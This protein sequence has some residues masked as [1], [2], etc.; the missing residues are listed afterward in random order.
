MFRFVAL[1]AIFVVAIGTSVDWDQ[2][3]ASLQ[4]T[5]NNLQDFQRSLEKR[6]QMLE[7]KIM[8]SKISLSALL[9]GSQHCRSPRSPFCHHGWLHHPE[10]LL[11]WSPGYSRY[12]LFVLLFLLF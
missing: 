5:N 4:E 11:R 6:V 3:L 2:E 7:E 10:L 12:A 8:N 1:A 9:I